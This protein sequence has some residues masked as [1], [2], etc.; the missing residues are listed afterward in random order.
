MMV[1]T[2]K[3]I[4]VFC[5][6]VGLCT[7]VAISCKKNNESIPIGEITGPSSVY[8][9]ENNVEYSIAA[10]DPDYYILWIVPEQ[11]EILSGQGKSR[12]KVNFGRKAGDIC[13]RFYK[14]GNPE[15]PQTCLKVD[16]GVPGKWSR[17]TD[18]TSGERQ[19]AVAFTIGEKGYLATGLNANGIQNDVWEFDPNEYSWTQKSNIGAYPRTQ[20]VG[21]SIGNKGYI[22]TGSNNQGRLKD[23]W[24]FDPVTNHWEQKADCGNT[25]RD[26]AFAF[27]T[28]TRGYIGG[29]TDAGGTVL[30]DIYEYNP[31]VN[32]WAQ[33]TPMP[34]VREGCAVFSIGNKGFVATE[35]LI[36]HEND[37]WMF[38]PSD[39]SNG[40]DANN[41]PL[42]KWTSKPAITGLPRFF[43]AGF[44]IGTSGYI[45]TGISNQ[46]NLNDLWEYDFSIDTGWVQ[47][48][49]ISAIGRAYSAAFSI[50][51]KGYVGTGADALSHKLGDFWMYTK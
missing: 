40:L 35:D 23:F 25:L 37:F 8:F 46:E 51:N 33:K 26:A 34:V 24:E 44:A 22:G 30:S 5:I 21:F 39:P 18:F 31:T 3:R 17:I 45:A 36:N 1:Y 7:L 29:G 15:S 38:D 16:F 43:A 41:N 12:I 9:G 13:A 48:D 10:V 32:E 4:A 49:T 47:R 14:K 50:S 11:A 27:S 2:N 19:M 42:G 6:M 28:A 20:A